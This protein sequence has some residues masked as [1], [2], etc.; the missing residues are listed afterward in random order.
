MT[1]A[2]SMNDESSSQLI[3]LR[4]VLGLGLSLLRLRFGFNFWLRFGFSFWLRRSL[5]LG[6]D[7]RLSLSSLSFGTNNKSIGQLLLGALTK[8]NSIDPRLNSNS[9]KVLLSSIEV[10]PPA[11]TSIK[12]NN[13]HSRS[14]SQTQCSTQDMGDRVASGD[15][16]QWEQVCTT[17]SM[18][19]TD[20]S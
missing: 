3:V 20:L 1:S 11:P 9:T 18:L 4:L 15:G 8:T 2:F 14:L 10:A 19:V 5:G 13:L 12:R 16:I 6:L 17:L 7:H